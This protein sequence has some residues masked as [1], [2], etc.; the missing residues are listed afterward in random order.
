MVKKKKKKNKGPN[1]EIWLEAPKKFGT[2]LGVFP[3]KKK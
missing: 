1:F 2:T 3:T